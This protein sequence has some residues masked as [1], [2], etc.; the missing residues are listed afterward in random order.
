MLRLSARPGRT[1]HGITVP[2][3]TYNTLYRRLRTEIAQLQICAAQIGIKGVATSC[4]HPGVPLASPPRLCKAELCS[5]TLAYRSRVSCTLHCCA[6]SVCAPWRCS[7]CNTIYEVVFLCFA[8]S[9]VLNL[10]AGVWCDELS[11]VVLPLSCP[12][13]DGSLKS[14]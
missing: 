11:I 3:S 9:R 12:G 8:G 1:D 5:Y 7:S 6:R 14:I 2:L 4:E 13:R 10:G